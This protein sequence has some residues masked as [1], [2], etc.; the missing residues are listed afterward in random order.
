MSVRAARQWLA[1]I[2][3]LAMSAVWASAVPV[4]ALTARVTDTTGTLD[5]AQVQLLESR[6]AELEARKGA[7]LAVLIVASTKP[8]PIEQYAL[9]AVEQWKLGRKKVDD[10]AL[11]IVAKAD[12]TLRIEVGYGLEGALNDAVSKRIVSDVIAPRFAQGD[13]A[14]GIEAGVDSMIRVVDGEPL[15]KPTDA[16][17]ASEELPPYLPTLVVM[18]LAAGV[19]LRIFMGR[20]PA[21]LTTGAIVGGAAWYFAGAVSTAL[22]AGAIA[23]LSTLAGGLGLLAR[24]AGHGRGGWGGGRGG[25]FRGGGGGFGGGG[26]TG[27][28]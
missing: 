2:A 18:T 7:Q 27:R 28:W 14:G 8:E 21:S 22:L 24:A 17:E 1:A 4:P 13:F 5:P 15:P 6:L 25:G 10:G 3:L 9:R 23:V 26:S 16:R 12:R 20:L 11:L 19:I